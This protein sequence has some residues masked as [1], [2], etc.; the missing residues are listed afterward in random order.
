MDKLCDSNRLVV[1][2][3]D[4]LLPSLGLS[5]SELELIRNN[6]NIIIHAASAIN[7]GSRLKR[8]SDSII[9]ASEMMVNL[10]F[11]CKGLHRFVCLLRIFKHTSLLSES[12]V[13]R[14]DQ[15]GYLPT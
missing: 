2:D 13:R 10:A 1:L 9:E 5:Q 14:A 12:R 15:R 3:G 7:L 8:V 4:I 6:T 11:T